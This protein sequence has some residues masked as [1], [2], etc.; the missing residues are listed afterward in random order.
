ME[1]AISSSFDLERWLE[2]FA[3]CEG[4]V[5]EDCPIMAPLAVPQSYTVNDVVNLEIEAFAEK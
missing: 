4:I 1:L 5:I 3:R 2:A